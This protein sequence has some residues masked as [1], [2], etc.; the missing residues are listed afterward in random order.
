MHGKLK[1]AMVGLRKASQIW[2]VLGR[3]MFRSREGN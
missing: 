3:Y 2:R 1:Y